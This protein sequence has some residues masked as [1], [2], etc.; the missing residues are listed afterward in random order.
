MEKTAYAEVR[1]PLYDRPWETL[2]DL[3]ATLN[4]VT[5]ELCIERRHEQDNIE[6]VFIEIEWE[7]T[8]REDKEFMEMVGKYSPHQFWL[9]FERM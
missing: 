5:H 8:A 9:R 2:D 7:Q 1:I 4:Q 3:F 6:S